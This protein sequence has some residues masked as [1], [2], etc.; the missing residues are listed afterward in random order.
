MKKKT[1]PA[2]TRK[3]MG[4]LKSLKSTLINMI[5]KSCEIHA[6]DWDEHLAHLL[7]AYTVSA[8]ESTKESPFYLLYGRDPQISTKTALSHSTSSSNVDPDD[9]EVE[10]MATLTNA[11]KLA[12][13]HTRFNNPRNIITTINP[14]R[15][16]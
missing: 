12:K 9:Y 10:L 7:F 16:L 14:N 5:A 4:W 1:L 13:E 3:Q 8:Q 15:L 11:L 6:H 2:A